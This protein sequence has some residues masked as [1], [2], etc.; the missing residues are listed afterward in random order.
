M[1]SVGMR[2]DRRSCVPQPSAF[3]PVRYHVSYCALPAGARFGGNAKRSKRIRHRR[4]GLPA[5][6]TG[7]IQ[8]LADLGNGYQ[9]VREMRVVPFALQDV[10][11][12]AIATAVPLA[13]VLLTACRST[14]WL[15]VLSRLF[16]D[17]FGRW[18]WSGCAI[19]S[20]D[21]VAR[22]WNRFARRRKPP[23]QFV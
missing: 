15:L 19:V 14:S 18:V 17:P 1:K 16:L 22:E 3:A 2:T 9:V 7:D 8:S 6:G 13:P 11:R 4:L 12:L 10:S 23:T 21:A 20:L 5:R